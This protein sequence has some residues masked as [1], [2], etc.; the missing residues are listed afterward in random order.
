MAL[1]ATV[2]LVCSL[3]TN[4]VFVMIFLSLIPALCML[5]GAVWLLA[6]DYEGNAQVAAKLEVVW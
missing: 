3:R 6:D 1:L 5:T 2:Y 4:I